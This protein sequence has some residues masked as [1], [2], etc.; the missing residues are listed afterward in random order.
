MAS[1]FARATRAMVCLEPIGKYLLW[2]LLDFKRDLWRVSLAED[3]CSDV[4][5]FHTAL[6]PGSELVRC[7]QLTYDCH[8]SDFMSKFVDKS[9]QSVFKFFESR[10]VASQW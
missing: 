4:D 5:P 9:V 8:R 10:M 6:E 2:N 7:A 1:M 3:P